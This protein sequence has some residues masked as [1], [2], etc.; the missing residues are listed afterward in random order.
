MIEMAGDERDINIAALADG[1]TVVERFENREAPRMLL[2]LARHGV[3]K[4]RPRVRRKFLPAGQGLARGFH[5]GV[6]VGGAS[7][8][9]FGKNCARGGVGGFEIFAVD[10]SVPSAANEMSEAPVVA[11]EPRERLLGIF[12]RGAVF[13][14]SE[15]F[16]DAAHDSFYPQFPSPVIASEARNLPFVNARKNRFLGQTPPSQRPPA[17]RVSSRPALL[18]PAWLRCASG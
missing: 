13:H 10:G 18:F 5:R 4:A 15:F 7:L 11:S 8:R 12:R 14:G 6:H 16:N 1:L 17:A 2:H 3:E 9:D